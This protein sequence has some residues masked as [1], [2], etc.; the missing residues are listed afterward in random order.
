M[1]NQ[2]GIYAIRNAISGKVYIGSSSRVSL[3][4]SQHR[5]A[6]KRN[7]HV[8]KRLQASWNK[9]GASAFVF[10]TV[11]ECGH[12][13]LLAREQWWINHLNAEGENGYNLTCAAR[14]ETPSIRASAQRKARWDGLSLD[15]RKA[16]ASQFQTASLKEG[17]RDRMKKRWEDPAYRAAMLERLA[18]GRDKTNARKDPK[19]L[20][21]LAAGRQ[22]AI[23]FG[24]S[25]EGREFH[26]Q[27]VARMMENPEFR[28]VQ[29]AAMDSG[30]IKLNL[31]KKEQ[32]AARRAG[33]DIV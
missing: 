31:R 9:H 13:A 25:E 22:K 10:E 30:R 16:K 23:A 3:R 21:N 7:D 24:I 19:I 12:E 2:P 14:S 33:N 27:K 4:L 6:L 29:I 11:E 1:K 17:N 20:A 28:A 18:R 32:A 8:N 15:E 26:R 5:W